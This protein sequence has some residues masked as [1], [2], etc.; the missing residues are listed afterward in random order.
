MKYILGIDVGT[1]NV[2]AVLF[3]EGGQEVR[4][5]SRESETINGAGNHVEQDMYVVWENVKACVKSVM[6]SKADGKEEIVGVGVTGQGE[7]CWL[8]DQEGNPV[9]NAILWCDGRAVKEV[10]EITKEHPEIGKLYHKT[11]GT[12]PLLGNQMMLL[13][14]MKENRQEVLD[15]A[16]KLMFCKD[17]I[18]YKMTEKIQ[19]EITDSL[20]SLVDV[21]SG[22]IAVELMEALGIAKYRDYLSDPVRSDEVVGTLLDSFA[23]EVGLQRGLPVI[24][25]AL[26]TSATAV[27]LGAIHE[28][29]VC[30]ILGTTCANEIVLKKEDCDFGAE[31]SRFEKHPLGELYVE[32][33]PTLNGTPNIDWMLEHIAQT[34]DFQ[35]IDKMVSKTPVGCGGVVYH[36][37]ISVAGERAPFY[38]PYARASFFGISQVTTREDLIRAVYEGISMSIRDCLQNVDKDATI[39][40]AG[41]GAKSPVWAQM[42]ADVLGLKVMI[43]AGREL[44]AKGV[45]LMVGVRQGLYKDYEEAVKKACT[46]RQVYHPNLVNTRKYDL[47]YELYKKVRIHNQEIWDYRHQMNKK[48]KAISQEEVK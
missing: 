24:A 10:G 34:K 1:S 28:K 42:I 41:G 36:P 3:D 22:K 27:G 8:I 33:Q 6:A 5:A 44:G 46:F 25:G 32:L 12:P 9:Q 40:L 21:E 38:H 2:K 35:E 14:W 30:V 15:K 20:T 19:T 23:D 7:G 45:A 37:Y 39:Y 47:I 31:N 48:I 13:K 16:D 18:R 29:D 11:T 43:P 26:D 17:W 4:V